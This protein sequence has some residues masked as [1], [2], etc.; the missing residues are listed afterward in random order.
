M[1]MI[2]ILAVLLVALVITFITLKV[3]H[4]KPD[5]PDLPDE[6]DPPSE[7]VGVG[8][9]S[10]STPLE[11]VITPPPATLKE[12]Q[13]FGKSASECRPVS[14]GNTVTLA[15]TKI[16]SN[17]AIMV[18]ATT[19]KVICEH[20]ADTRIFPASMTKLMTVIVACELIED[21]N[22]T[23]TFTTELL[24][25]IEKGATQAYFKAG[26]PVPMKDL[27]YGVILPSGADA[28]LGLA[29][30]LAGSEEE[31]VKLMNKKALELG[32][33]DT[34][35]M[36][37]SGLHHEEH[38]ST[39]RDIATIMAY[40][41]ENSYLR[42][43]ITARSYKTIAPVD[44]ADGTLYCN[45]QSGYAAD[46]SSK[47]TMIGAKSGYTELAGRCLASISRTESG[48]E[49]IIVTA[50]AFSNDEKL[51]TEQSF[52]DVRYLCDTYIK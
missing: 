23:F 14:D 16:Y 49:Y 17:N 37:V 13:T 12:W 42:K 35:F 22:D 5:V 2:I 34:H 21:M 33:Y 32:C 31:F 38:Y 24:Y 45:W 18:N 6:T 51:G 47:A 26:N 3:S 11:S 7:S 19:G 8:E 41:M 40:A 20:E 27:L 36:N 1:L 39:V 50:G 46:P 44:R 10:E 52:A 43:I 48:V 30:S 25:S 28:C 9:P 29:V 15:S 4:N